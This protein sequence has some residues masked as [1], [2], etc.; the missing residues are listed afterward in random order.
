MWIK[1]RKVSAELLVWTGLQCK[2]NLKLILIRAL[3][4][5]VPLIG[6]FGCGESFSAQ[7]SKKSYLLYVFR[8]I[9]VSKA[10]MVLF[11]RHSKH[12]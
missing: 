2:R 3:K 6:I 1:L 9:L 4:L 7:S 5:S 11:T 12:T 10:D 8:N